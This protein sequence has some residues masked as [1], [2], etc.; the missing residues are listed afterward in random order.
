MGLSRA[1]RESPENVAEL[2][3]IEKAMKKLVADVKKLK[4]KV[5]EQKQITGKTGQVHPDTAFKKSENYAKVFLQGLMKMAADKGY[6]GVALS[7]GKM[8]KAHGEIPKGGDKFYDEIGVKAM[9]RIAKKSGFKFKDT[10]IVDGNGYTWEKIPLIEM[11]D[12]NTGQRI[13]GESTIPVYSK[14]G[15]VKQNMVRGNNNGY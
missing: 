10:T 3:N 9:K 8:K 5:E 4:A 7:T 13:P 1:E 6:D 15:F 2:K 11:R 14:G 12:I